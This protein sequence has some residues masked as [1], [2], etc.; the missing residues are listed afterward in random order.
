MYYLRCGHRWHWHGRRWLAAHIPG[1]EAWFFDDEGHALREATS[2]TY[3]P[4]S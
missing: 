4:G 2:K 1:V 3:T